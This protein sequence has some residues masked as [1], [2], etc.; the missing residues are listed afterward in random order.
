M[1][2][3]HKRMTGK[4]M[5]DVFGGSGFLTTATNHLGLRSFVLDT[6]FDSRDDV[7]QPL[8][9]H[10]NS[11]RR[12]R[13]KMCRRDDFTSTTPHFV[14]S[15]HY[16]RQCFHRKLASSCSHAVDSGTPMGFVVL[17][18]TENRSSCGTASRGLGL[19]GQCAGTGGRCRLIQQLSHHTQ[20]FAFHVITSAFFVYLSRYS[21]HHERTT[22][23]ENPSLS[24]NGR[25]VTQ[26]A[27][28][29]WYGSYWSCAHCEPNPLID[30]RYSTVL[31]QLPFACLKLALIV[32][33]DL[34]TYATMATHD[35]HSLKNMMTAFCTLTISSKSCHIATFF[36]VA[37]LTF[38]RLSSGFTFGDSCT[39]F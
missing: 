39:I 29:Y 10:Q 16:F 37:V 11:T 1:S 12:F 9:S 24:W 20:S 18:R 6:K 30:A 14:L 19:G 4:Y 13:W 7:T 31:A 21:S 22:F 35:S 23:P 32:R 36:T 33:T 15:Q 26:R 8:V 5:V 3:T 38:L 27:K 17:G 2:S 34:L 28:G 25:S